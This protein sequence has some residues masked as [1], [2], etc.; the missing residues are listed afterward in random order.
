[1]G[2]LPPNVGFPSWKSVERGHISLERFW[3]EFLGVLRTSLERLI[4]R[5]NDELIETTGEQSLTG[6]LYIDGSLMVGA[7]SKLVWAGSATTTLDF[8]SI[9]AQGQAELTATLTGVVGGEEVVAQ[10]TSDPEAGLVW[11]AWAPTTD[12]VKVRMI[13][14]TS[15]PIDP[16][17]RTWR[18]TARRWTS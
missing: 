4:R 9:P 1:M 14:I 13:N 12:T 11:V 2:R 16:A 5:T 18:V 17:S 7:S 8:P 6:T 10:P 3:L 15:S